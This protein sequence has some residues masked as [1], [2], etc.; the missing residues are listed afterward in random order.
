VQG[1]V[2]DGVTPLLFLFSL[3]A[4]P[5]TQQLY[6]ISFGTS[7]LDTNLW[8]LGSNGWTQTNLLVMSSTNGY[9]YLSG[10]RAE[11]LDFTGTNELT[12]QLNL[13]VTGLQT[14]VTNTTFK[15]R[16]PPIMLVHGYNSDSNTWSSDF[17]MTLHQ[18]VPADF[19]QPLNYGV[20]Y[21]TLCSVSST[22]SG[23]RLQM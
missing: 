16:R 14:P 21:H 2:A 13:S 22:P 17:L 6:Q 11:D 3:A 15:I 4:Q 7:G 10:L 1:V 18:N 9:A 23:L 19:V 20:Q 8:V 5:S 12:V